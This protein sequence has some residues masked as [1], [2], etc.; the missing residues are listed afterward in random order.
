MYC[1]CKYGDDN[2]ER[3]KS[4]ILLSW[5]FEMLILNELVI[6]VDPQ[7]ISGI[8]GSTIFSMKNSVK[9]F[10]IYWKSLLFLQLSNGFESHHFGIE[11]AVP[12]LKKLGAKL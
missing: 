2:L 12:S 10:A 11:T 3:N 8:W 5:F 9:L 1:R 7:A 4:S 6:V